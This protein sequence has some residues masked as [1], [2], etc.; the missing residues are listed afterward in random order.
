[1]M[2]SGSK[3]AQVRRNIVLVGD[4]ATERCKKNLLSPS[5]CLNNTPITSTSQRGMATNIP[6]APPKAKAT[7]SPLAS[8]SQ[9]SNSELDKEFEEVL[10]CLLLFPVLE[11]LL[12]F[13]LLLQRFVSCFR[14]QNEKP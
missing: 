7:T 1:M 12:F 11:R 3:V 8:T 9:P 2:G 6:K 14:S 13:L 4:G 5:P 10:V